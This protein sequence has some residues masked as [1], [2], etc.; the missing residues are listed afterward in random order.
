MATLAWV[1][2]SSPLSRVGWR[3][4]GGWGILASLG[5]SRHHAPAATQGPLR[6]LASLETPAQTAAADSEP[7]ADLLESG[8]LTT[9]A[10]RCSSLPSQVLKSTPKLLVQSHPQPQEKDGPAGAGGLLHLPTC[11]SSC[12]ME[13]C[14]ARG[15]T[16]CERTHPSPERDMAAE[17][18]DGRVPTRTAAQPG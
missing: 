6:R 2:V 1:G 10:P 5:A 11:S 3:Q 13:L 12:Q 7:L 9:S 8:E 17:S 4:A 15:W 16:D 18:K 14:S